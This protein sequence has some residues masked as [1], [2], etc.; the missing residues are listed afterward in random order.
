VGR[1][2]LMT[3]RVGRSLIGQATPHSRNRPVSVICAMTCSPPLSY[4]PK[5][6]P[7][8]T[9]WLSEVVSHIASRFP[10]KVAISNGPALRTS[11]PGL[12]GIRTSSSLRGWLTVRVR[13]RTE[14]PFKPRDFI[15]AGYQPDAYLQERMHAENPL[16]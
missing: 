7:F 5:R 12:A 8:L 9:T 16:A 10:R 15:C 2:V 13:S 3:R 11:P 1:P 6:Y 14:K 4:T